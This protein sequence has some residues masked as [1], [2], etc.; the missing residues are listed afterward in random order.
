VIAIL[1]EPESPQI[2]K[3]ELSEPDGAPPRTETKDV[4]ANV[5]ASDNNSALLFTVT[6]SDPI[7]SPSNFPAE[8]ES[9]LISFFIVSNAMRDMSSAD[10]NSPERLSDPTITAKD[11]HDETW[12]D[13]S[14]A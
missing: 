13:S 4:A 1:V 10:R 7:I 3:L 12:P 11:A 5:V 8:M 9:E 14:R 2:S 6:D